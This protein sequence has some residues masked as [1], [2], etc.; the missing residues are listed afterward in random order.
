MAYSF[1]AIWH[2]MS[3]RFRLVLVV[4]SV[5]VV[6][7]G[8]RIVLLAQDARD[9]AH[10]AQQVQGA[11]GYTQYLTRVPAWLVAV[12]I[13]GVIAVWCTALRVALPLWR[14]TAS[15]APRLTVRTK[16]C[17]RNSSSARSR[18]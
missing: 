8:V 13:L 5:I 12:H 3:L 1:S 17:S 11:I 9:S 15:S 16:N 2:A 7:A 18:K 10:Q 14:A 4:T 6:H